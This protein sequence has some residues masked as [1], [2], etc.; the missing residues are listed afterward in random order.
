MKILN[1]T[2]AAITAS[3]AGVLAMTSLA[4]AADKK[5]EAPRATAAVTDPASLMKFDHVRVINATPTQIAAASQPQKS[6]AGMKAFADPATGQLRA[7]TPE[8]LATLAAAE[9]SAQAKVAAPAA[10][11]RSAAP[12]QS[13]SA[14]PTLGRA[15]VALDDSYMSYAVA[16]VGKD[17][18]VTQSCLENQPNDKAAL[19]AAA[20]AA[21]EV[22][23]HEK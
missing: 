3:V 9:Q 22:N 20:E 17:G 5:A 10:A 1:I 15:A 18:K 2:R 7:P 16:V 8:D 13:L 6:T 12:S 11:K 14:A 4:S 23:R 19:A 21:A